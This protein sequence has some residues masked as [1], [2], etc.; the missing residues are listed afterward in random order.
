MFVKKNTHAF[1]EGSDYMQNN[2][3]EYLTPKQFVAKHQ[4]MP[5]GGL[6]HLLF[7]SKE[8]GLE[9]AILKIG[10]KK[11]LISEVKF[12]EWLHEQNQGGE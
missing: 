3:S 8:N 10:K 4:F 11:I 5:M 9:K 7:H 2:L 6:R 1:P 12:F